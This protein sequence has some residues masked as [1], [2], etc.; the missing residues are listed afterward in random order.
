MTYKLAIVLLVSIILFQVRSSEFYETEE[1][2]WWKQTESKVE[3][4]EEAEAKSVKKTKEKSA[5]NWDAYLNTESDEFY[6]NGDKM[7]PRPVIEAMKNQTDENI[8]NY[9]KW[10][11]KR[12]NMAMKFSKKIQS[13]VVKNQKENKRIK[14]PSLRRYRFQ[15]YFDSTCPN[16]K[17]MSSTVIGLDRSGFDVEAVQ[18]D[19]GNQMLEYKFKTRWVIQKDYKKHNL[20]GVPLLVI[21][22]LK[23]RQLFYIDGYVTLEEV[24]S[25]INRKEVL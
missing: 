18:L 14:T 24:Y 9:M 22:D 20:K 13:Y 23:R 8:E 17:K 4:V 21:A 25:F 7:P 10:Q 2:N 12:T 6:R 5:F 16:C 1:I 19:T 11:N 15:Y 3:K